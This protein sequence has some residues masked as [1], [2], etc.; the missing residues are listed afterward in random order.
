MKIVARLFRV[1]A[2]SARWTPRALPSLARMLNAR[3]SLRLTD[4][5]GQ[6]QHSGFG[7][8][9]KILSYLLPS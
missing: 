3:G 1:N 9:D 7:T 2:E 8:S 5:E 4:L 6:T